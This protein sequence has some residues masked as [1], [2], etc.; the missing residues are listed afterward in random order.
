MSVQKDMKV[1]SPDRGFIFWPVGSGDSTTVVVDPD[2]YIQIDLRHLALADEDDED[3]RIAIIDKLEEILPIVDGKPFLSVFVLT[4]PDEDHCRGFEDLLSRVAIGELWH[5]PRVFREGPKDL[6]Y[7]AKAFRREAKRRVAKIIENDGH[8]EAGDRVRIIGYDA[9]LSEDDYKGFPSDLLS[10]PG[11]CLT[12][13]NGLDYTDRFKAFIHG[14]F[15][16]DC[17]GDR[18]DTSVALQIS[19][20]DGESSAKALF[21]GDLCYPTVNRIFELSEADDVAW[22]L[23]LSPHHCSKSVMYWK[24]EGEAEASLKQDI[25]DSMADAAASPGFIIASSQPIPSSNESG[26]NPPHAIAKRRYEEIVPDKFLCTQEH[27]N[28][29]IPEPIIFALTEN[30]LEYREPSAEVEEKT[31]SMSAAVAGARGTG[32]PPQDRVGFGKKDD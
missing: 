8:S 13:L 7:D 31:Y 25:L 16:D 26:D 21:F 1:E 32:A 22:N 28:K 23:L 14:P 29:D 30:G 27:P 2:T 5:A 12:I 17:E 19:L 10:I 20:Y 4:H 9:L 18:N 11:T 15:K 3:P 24:S 6:C